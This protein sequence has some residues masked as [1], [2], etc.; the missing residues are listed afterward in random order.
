MQPFLVTMTSSA[1]LLADFH[2]HLTPYEVCGYLAGTWD[3]NS[4]S[5][6]FIFFNGSIIVKSPTLRG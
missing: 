6:Y 5:M 3:V 4:H 1:M 2:C